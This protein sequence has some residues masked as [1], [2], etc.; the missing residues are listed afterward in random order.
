MQQVENNR[1]LSL[2][3]KDNKIQKWVPIKS[4]SKNIL[5][6]AIASEDQRFVEH[7]GFDYIEFKHALEDKIDGKRE[8]GASTI[9]QQVAKNLFLFPAKSFLRKGIELY[10]S[11]IIEL[12][13]DKK[14]I[15]EVYLNIAQFG[16]ELYGVEA[17]SNYYFNKPSQFLSENEAAEL[18]AVL[19][20]P[21][22]YNLKNKSKFLI[23]RIK[24]IKQNSVNIRK[25]KTLEIIIR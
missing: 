4:I 25:G 13:W 16:D 23:H 12:I 19:P 3:T 9:T 24:K 10:Y 21:I 6:A 20:N 11:I 5:F 22:K 14:R 18:V 2:L 8:R 17:A 1:F 7:Y 15:L